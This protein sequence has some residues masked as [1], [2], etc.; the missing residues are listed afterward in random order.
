MLLG[1]LLLT[2]HVS[3][4]QCA[5]CSVSASSNGSYN[6]SGNQ[7]LCITADVNSLNINLNG[8]NNTICVASGVAWTHTGNLSFNS[9]T[10]INVYGTFNMNGSYNFNGPL[11]INVKPGG[12]LNTNTS[13]FQN[14]VTIN[15]EGTVTFTRTGTVSHTGTTFYFNNVGA[16]SR[17][18]ATAPSQ[19]I[20]G[21]GTSVT[22]QG[23]MD[24]R[25]IEN[26]DS[27]LF[28]NMTGG[29]VNIGGF[30]NNHGGMLNDG[31]INTVCGKF[32]E[33]GVACGF[34]LG[35]KSAS[36]T[37]TN[38]GCISIEGDVSL[39]IGF[40]DGIM[41]IKPGAP[42]TGNLTLNKPIVGTNGAIYVQNGYSQIL[43]DGMLTGT[44]MKFYSETTGNHDFNKKTGNQPSNYTVEKV[45]TSCE[46]DPGLPPITPL[47]VSLARF[48]AA[49]E[50]GTA[51][52]T[53]E[54]TAETNSERFEVERSYNGK[55]W[56]I[57]GSVAARGESA[58]LVSYTFQDQ[59]PMAGENLYRL[60]MIDRDGT[61]AYSTLQS[62]R[63]EGRNEIVL[64]P[65]PAG[66]IL[67][68]TSGDWGQIALF[69][70][71]SPGG[72]SV[73]I[74]NQEPKSGIDVSKL[75]AGTYVA[76]ISTKNGARRSYKVVIAR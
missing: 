46:T 38:K 13:G 42:G 67:K 3:E 5:S 76:V 59:S 17:L 8:A 14:N 51:T 62:L 52:L 69:E 43:N 63:F 72:E 64:F 70:L 60:K 71:R 27:K 4:S 29:T 6:L 40:N 12:Q 45:A 48:T 1:T 65:N 32:G 7:T 66:E 9:A 41:I 55:S 47:P 35:D 22:N 57:L 23:T 25:N 11:L 30:L 15:N 68:V 49:A 33:P 10:T 36:K 31:V 54:T 74:T 34:L 16:D 75:P 19:F 56:S 73:Y 21:N 18:I 37:F 53:W 24:F 61:Y 58:V 26:A 28:W 44:G 50:N 20:F 2:A 39:S